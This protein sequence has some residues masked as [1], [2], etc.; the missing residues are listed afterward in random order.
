MKKSVFLLLATAIILSGCQAKTAASGKI[1]VAASFYPL[2]F[3]ASQI[4]GDKAD[5]INITQAGTE[6]HDYEPT[7]Q[8]MAKIENSRILILNGL[9]LEAWSDNIQKNIDPQKTSVVLGGMG[10]D[11]VCSIDLKLYPLPLTEKQKENICQRQTDPHIW[12]APFMA[13]N[14]VQNIL[15]GFVKVDPANAEYYQ[16][17]AAALKNKLIALDSEYQNGLA[18]CQLKTFITSHNAFGYLAQIYGLRQIAIAGLSPDAEPSSAQLIDVAKTAKAENI[19]YIFFE[20]LA[21]PK[22]SQ[23]IAAEVGAQT[24]ILDPIEGLTKDEIANGDNYFTVEENNLKNLQIALQ[25][26][27]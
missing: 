23:T 2:Y 26:Q 15:D 3:F 22:L 14:I 21:S 1:Q 25:C 5:V 18:N 6:P 17:N 12:I 27:K 20:S 13:T 7:A 19:K 24:L 8:D 10:M 4:G 11:Q 16:T 9:G